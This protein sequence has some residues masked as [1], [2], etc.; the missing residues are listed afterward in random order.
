MI[1]REYLLNHSTKSR[2]SLVQIAITTAWLILLH[3]VYLLNTQGQNS[4]Y[5]TP[6]CELEDQAY[7]QAIKLFQDSLFQFAEQKYAFLIKRYPQNINQDDIFYNEIECLYNSAQ[8]LEAANKYS[9]YVQLYPKSQFTP[10][11]Y[12]RLGQIYFR[13]SRMSD[14]LIAFKTLLEQYS[15]HEKSGE[16]AYWIGKIY[17]KMDDTQNAIK[18]FTLSYEN[19]PVNVVT[20]EAM[21]AIAWTYQKR[22][23]YSRAIELYKKMIKEFPQSPFASKA[24]VCL[25]ECLFYIKD[26]FSAI[27]ELKSFR[28]EIQSEEDIGNADYLIAEAY[29]KTGKLKDARECYERFLIHHQKHILS[30]EVKFALGKCYFDQAEFTLAMQMFDSLANQNDEIGMKALFHRALVERAL[31]KIDISMQTLNDLLIR[32]PQ[33]EWSDNALYELGMIH[34]DISEIANAYKYF[35]RL[36]NEFP[37]SELFSEA[38]LMIG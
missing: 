34:Y 19:Y 1:S 30:S 23:E 15:E 2:L 18:Y 29:N 16:G 35:L 27:E 13:L 14:A 22:K 9:I 31:G 33:N 7:T 5:S 6:S 26:Y 8:L 25:G 20:Q 24:H 38:S 3:F 4:F 21:F 12:F 11:V 37:L 10:F 36:T 28:G 32:D 17:L